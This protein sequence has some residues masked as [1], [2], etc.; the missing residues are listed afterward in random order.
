MILHGKDGIDHINIYSKTETKLGRWLTNFAY[1]EF[2]V[3]N[4]AFKSVEG[5][6][7]FLLSDCKL[8][9]LCYLYGFEAKQYGKKFCSNKYD[10]NNIEFKVKIKKAIDEKIKSDKE[11]L[12]LFSESTL[13]FCHYYVYGDKKVDAGYDWIISHIEDRRTL[14]KNHFNSLKSNPSTSL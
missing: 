10:D 2:C 3:D 13:P 12:K 5:Y 7:Y 4:L 9:D 11:M 6:W 8:Y 14:L 1:S